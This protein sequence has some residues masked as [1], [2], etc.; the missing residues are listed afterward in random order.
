MLSIM[1]VDLIQSKTSLEKKTEPV[2]AWMFHCLARDIR[3]LLS[4]GI[5]LVLSMTDIDVTILQAILAS[6]SVGNRVL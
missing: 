2:G 4:G 3:P 1:W 5:S 6:Q